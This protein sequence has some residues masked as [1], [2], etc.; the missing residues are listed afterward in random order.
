MRRLFAVSLFL[1]FAS[2]AV[3][4]PAPTE[5]WGKAG[6]SFEQ[7]RRDSVECGR[8][9]YY[10]DVSKT[11]DAKEFVRASHQLDTLNRA[12]S[13]RTTSAGST[14]PVST[15]AVNQMTGFAVS[16][17]HIIDGVRPEERFRNIKQTLQ[18][19]TDNCLV[20]RGYSKFTLTDDQSHRLRKLK[21]GSA[22]RHAY[23]FKLAADP[24][25][26]A[27]QAVPSLPQ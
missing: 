4:A 18:S 10:L 12:M 14:G 11:E 6:V 17:Q 7:Y 15:D 23:L 3:A 5:S 19:T 20:G 9:G 26:L 13:P 21:L 8:E 25:I 1:L 2:S 24:T 16:Q 22:G 27:T